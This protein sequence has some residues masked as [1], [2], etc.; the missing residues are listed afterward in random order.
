MTWHKSTDVIDHLNSLSAR[1]IKKLVAACTQFSEPS[2]HRFQVVQ[3][4]I[5]WSVRIT[6]NLYSAVFLQKQAT[7]QTILKN[8]KGNIQK[9]YGNWERGRE[10]EIA[11]LGKIVGW[12]EG[13]HCSK[14]DLWVHRTQQL[15]GKSFLVCKWNGIGTYACIIFT[16]CHLGI[17]TI[18][19]KI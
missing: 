9:K 2:K 1:R 19:I 7:Q 10:K 16:F 6:S 13:S 3:L 12:G 8:K 5:M 11:H 17:I 4:E 15:Q 18:T 14:Q